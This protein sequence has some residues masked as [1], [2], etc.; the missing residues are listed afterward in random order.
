MSPDYIYKSDA[1]FTVMG[2]PVYATRN[3]RDYEDRDAMG[4]DLNGR[5]VE[6]DGKEFLV[7]G[8]ESYAIGGVYR[9]G[10][11]IALMVRAPE[12]IAPESV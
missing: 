10:R 4:R 6:I 12:I 1:E 9:K 8:V 11:E 2:N 7:I 3:N 5:L